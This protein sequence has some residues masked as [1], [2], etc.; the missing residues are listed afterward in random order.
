LG[1]GINIFLEQEDITLIVD[2]ALTDLISR[3]KLQTI[4]DAFAE[5]N[6]VAATIIDIYGVPIT[7]RSNHSKVCKMVRDSPKG[8]ANCIHS[9]ERLG[10]EAARRM[11]P[12]HMQCLSCGFS[13]AAVPIIVEGRHLGNWLIGQYHVGDV[14]EAH[15][16]SYG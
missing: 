2:Y 15:I 12:F 10:Q 13:D 5:A 14:D 8:L 7:R 3:E 11:E 9:G 4:Q 6:Q 1:G 16:S